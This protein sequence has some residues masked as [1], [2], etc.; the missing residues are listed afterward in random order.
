MGDMGYVVEVRE[1]GRAN[2][3]VAVERRTE[4]GRTS[5]DLQVG[6]PLVSRRH[7]VLVPGADGVTVAD[8]GSSNGTT[9]NDTPVD[10]ETTVR[11]GDVIGLGRVRIAVLSE[12]GGA[13]ASARPV[14]QP[15]QLAADQDTP[16]AAVVPGVAPRVE[17][18]ATRETEA[19]VFR[20]RPGTAGEA[21]LSGFV[22]KVARARKRLSGLG[23][24]PWGVRPVFCLVDPFPDPQDTGRMIARGTVVNALRGEIWMVVTPEA[25]PEPPERPLALFFGAALPAAEDLGLVLEGFGLAVADVEG[26]DEQLSGRPL[27]PLAAAEG[28]LRSVMALSFVRYLLEKGGRESLLRMMSTATAARVDAAAADVYGI[29]LAGLEER[30]RQKLAAAAAPGPRQFLRMSLPYL[31]ANIARELELAAIL[32]VQLSFSVAFPFAFRH[33]LDD[34]LPNRDLDAAIQTIVSLAVL[35]GISMLAGVRAAYLSGYVSSAIVRQLRAEMFSRLQMQ[36]PA[37]FAQRQQGDVLSRLMGD[38]AV[39]ERGLSQALRD[40]TF[41]LLSLLASAGVLVTLSLPLGGLVVGGAALVGIVYRIMGRHIQRRSVAV[42]EDTGALLSVAAENVA[43]QPVVRAFGLESREL[44]RF[45]RASDRLFARELKLQLFGGLF[46]LS[47]NAVAASLN[48]AVLAVG[49]WLVIDGHLAIGTFVVVMSQV[50]Q[51]ISPVTGLSG[52]GQQLQVATGALMRINEIVT[53]PPEVADQVGAARLRPLSAAIR[54]AH[55]DFGYPGENNVLTEIDVTIRAGSRVAFVGPTGAGKSTLLQLLLRFQDV[56]SGMILFDGVDIRSVVASSLRNQL[57]V[58]FQDT[59]L[60]DASVGENIALGADRATSA[61]VEAAARAAGI[62]EF[63]MSLPRGYDTRVGERGVRLSG[64]QRQRLAI[65]RA[66]VRNPQVLLLD[67]ATS[68]LDARTERAV[69]TAVNRVGSGRTVIAVT[70]RLASISDYDA[71][72][73]VVGGRIVESGTHDELLAGRGVYADLWAE[74]GGAAQPGQQ[75][76]DLLALL[77]DVSLFRD[78]SRAELT[79]VAE[80]LRH[81]RLAPGE[82]VAE[83]DG[84][85][86][87]IASGQA[88]VL[89]KDVTGTAVPSAQLGPGDVF[90]LAA[91]LGDDM[92]NILQPIGNLDLLVLDPAA[93]ARLTVEVPSLPKSLFGA[94]QAVA[95]RGGTRLSR[96]VLRQSIVM[97]RSVSPAALQDEKAAVWG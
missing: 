66:I 44:A 96:P 3:R 19:A 18:L 85:I 34:A 75:N 17:E 83:S 50:G 56:R 13:P 91:L 46:S 31:R 80:R 37:W 35:F 26:P 72:H 68:A 22:P 8:L 25:P 9:V 57:G 7:L 24:E 48:L 67:E 38:V 53:A 77:A 45:R 6:D 86:Y 1:P 71:I 33:L 87:V 39:Y 55:V 4:V 63:V 12:V 42:Q 14:P 11:A 49:A 64:G 28:E 94:E 84:R 69:M 41:Q 47:I 52:V 59:F 78:L 43:A 58:V 36:S 27:P 5:L 90:G 23:S 73:V 82:T 61:Q 54:F 40:G 10:R 70:H 93:I 29:G 88:R 20:Y 74:Q 60:F 95:P 65:A 76:V 97:Q 15:R 81:V 79:C 89:S 32:L 2:R 51:V 21:A 16:V 92:D 30:W 62:H